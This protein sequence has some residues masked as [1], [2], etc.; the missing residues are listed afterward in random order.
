MIR[1]FLYLT[2]TVL[3]LFTLGACSTARTVP[4]AGQNDYKLGIGDKVR[5]NVYNQDKLSGDFT[6]ETTGN[7]SL[8]LVES[9]PAA[10]LTT[11][12]LEQSI[13]EALQPEYL[14]DPK[15]SIEILNYRNVY[16][17]GEVEEPGKYEYVP[18]MTLLQAVATANGYT[19]RASEG[20]A[21]VTRHVKGALVV[22]D[23]DETTMLKPGDTVVINRRWF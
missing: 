15:V 2:L 16:V 17:L 5:V 22:F 4:L 7:I 6:V 10:G 9:I 8:P 14:N 12:E 3:A 20:G 18:N 21:T 1:P 19:P 11:A 13:K 23:V